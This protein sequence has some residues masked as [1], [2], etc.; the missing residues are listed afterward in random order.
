MPSSSVINQLIA[1][2]P[3]VFTRETVNIF[4][5]YEYMGLLWRG[6]AVLLID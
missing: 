3:E 1:A 2:Y 6:R 5:A 4:T